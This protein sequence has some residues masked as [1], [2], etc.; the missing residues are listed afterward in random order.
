MDRQH[1]RHACAESGEF[2]VAVI[3]IENKTDEADE[4]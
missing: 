3:L 1:S 4:S 2:G